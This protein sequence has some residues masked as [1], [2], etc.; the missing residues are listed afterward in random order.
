[1]PVYVKDY[2]RP[3]LVRTD[4]QNLNGAWDFAFDDGDHGEE[5]G[6]HSQFLCGEENF[7]PVYL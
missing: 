6:W 1:M 5:S 2:P 7:R 4:W 3:Q